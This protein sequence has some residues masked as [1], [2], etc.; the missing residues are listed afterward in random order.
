MDLKEALLEEHSKAQTMRIV[1]YIG[2]DKT[3]FATLMD[4]LFAN[5]EVVSAR[6]AWAVGHAAEARPNLAKPYLTRL[7]EN[8]RRPVHD[9]VRRNT[10]R[11]VQ[12]AELT[13]EQMGLA[14]DLCFEIVP[15]ASQPAAVRAYAL[16]IC[17]RV[18][19]AEPALCGELEFIIENFL[20][21][22]PPAV[23]SRARKVLK[24]LKRLAGNLSRGARA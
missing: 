14:A 10:L 9:A 18:C 8:L 12:E 2:S 11:L 5:E 17:Q 7:L 24:A 6:A 4:L 23:Q 22:S 16:T 13:E 19:E 15:D 3:R 20:H 1:D 21:G